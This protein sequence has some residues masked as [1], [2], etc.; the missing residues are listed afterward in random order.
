VGLTLQDLK[1]AMAPLAEIGKGEL[2]FEVNGTRISLRA[3]TPDEEIAVQRYSRSS[4][5]EGDLT[6]QTTALEYL[7]KFRNGSLGYSIVQIGNLDFRNVETIETGEKLANGTAIKVKRHEAI[8]GLVGNWSRNMTVAVFKKFGEL[9][10]QVEK[11]VEGLIEF[12]SIDFDGEITRLEDR[13]REL[14]EEKAR[15]TLSDADPRTN[16][17]QQV[18]TSGKSF[19]RPEAGSTAAATT[20]SIQDQQNTIQEAGT[21]SVPSDIDREIAS[22]EEESQEEP[23]EPSMDLLGAQGAAP[24]VENL[25][26][27]VLDRGTAGGAIRMP[28]PSPSKQAP[29][30]FQESVDE[31]APPEPTADPLSDVMSSMVDMGD[32]D[33]AEK[34]VEMETRRI[35]EMRA[36]AAKMSRKPPHVAAKQAA[37]EIERPTAAG[38]K[39]GVEV[40]KMPTQTLTDRRPPETVQAPVRSNANPRFKPTRSGG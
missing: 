28:P 34:A 20:D 7:D 14:K 18:A 2:T 37:Q 8:Q 24:P 27:S 12:E 29:E 39:D 35:M 36:N 23:E 40:Y 16:L 4:L 19:R 22:E 1:T 5:A 11:E 9:M 38:T 15:I 3:L 32:S 6:D 33:S 13:I 30:E 21:V 17:R 10:N 31:D 26:K 25:R